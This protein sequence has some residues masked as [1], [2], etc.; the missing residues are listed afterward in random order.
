MTWKISENRHAC[1]MD[2]GNRQHSDLLNLARDMP[3][4]LDLCPLSEGV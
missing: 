4:S 2:L 1:D 3:L